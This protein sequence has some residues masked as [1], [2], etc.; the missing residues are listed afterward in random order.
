MRNASQRGPNV[1]RCP[2]CRSGDVH[3][4]EMVIDG[5]HEKHKPKGNRNLVR[6]TQWKTAE[7]GPLPGPTGL[8]DGDVVNPMWVPR[9]SEKGEDHD[10]NSWSIFCLSL[11]LPLPLSLRITS[12]S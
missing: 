6:R 1:S 7:G 5:D 3:H 9:A 11:H 4:G 8:G 2:K 10:P 12:V